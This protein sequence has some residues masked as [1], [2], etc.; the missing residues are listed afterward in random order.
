MR[1]KPPRV[2][3]AAQVAGAAQQGPRIAPG[4]YT[5]RLTRGSDVITTKVTVGV[6]RR[7]KYTAADRKAQFDAAMRA[8]ALFDDMTTLVDHIDGARE[9]T[10]ERVHAVGAQDPLGKK[11]AALQQR[12][13]DLKKKVVATT[14]GG[15]ITGEERIREHLDLLYGAL[16]SYEGRPAKY[17]LDRIDV[18]RRELDD[19]K[20]DFGAAAKD[21]AGLNKEL[22]QKKLAPIPTDKAAEADRLDEHELECIESHGQDCEP[23]PDRAARHNER[24]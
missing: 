10:G 18:L 16:E 22:E 7:A 11:L 20:K 2:P 5:L 15:A 6:D 3:K 19:V 9:A 14:E 1:V 4:T 24:D 12:L 23:E 21:V 8:H 17:L 13:D